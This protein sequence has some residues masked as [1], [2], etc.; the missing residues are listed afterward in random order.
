MA[1]AII[2]IPEKRFVSLM[3][4]TISET[5]RDIFLDPDAGLELK[6]S[7]IDDLNSSVKS[8]KAGKLITF[9]SILKRYQK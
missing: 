3:R 1:E 9:E 8:K 2:T 6:E 5:I 4:Q 7:F